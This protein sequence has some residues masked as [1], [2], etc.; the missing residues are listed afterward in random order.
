MRVMIRM[1]IGILVAMRALQASADPPPPI[2]VLCGPTASGK[3][4]LSIDLAQLSDG[5][6]INADSMQVYRELRIVTA[7]PDAAAESAAPHALYGVTP[8]VERCSAGRWRDMAIQAIA[9][10]RADG[11]R[12]ILVGGSGLYLS[13]LLDGLSAIPA[14]GPAATAEGEAALARLGVQGLHADLA[15]IDPEAAA[16]L[17]PNDRQRILR[18][19]IVKRATGRSIVAWR[20]G[21]PT[22]PWPEPALIVALDP[23]RPALRATI[24]ARAASMAASGALDEAAAFLAVDTHHASPAAKAVGLRAFAAA[25][26]GET[27]LDTAIAQVAV[28]TAQ[29]AKRQTTWFR[30]R[31]APTIR[32]SEQ[33]SESL[34][35]S[36]ARK[37]LTERLT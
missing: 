12:P 23:P 2:I 18:A 27:S 6:V 8:A 37:I 21:S 17:A 9:D 32:I 7:R 3:S 30:K 16:A 20:R 34:R 10:A 1:A 26:A 33:L 29:Y 28:E 5:V 19:W 15:A 14:P 4:S 31:P 24:A 36:I 11:R 13:A 22:P 35:R 25:A